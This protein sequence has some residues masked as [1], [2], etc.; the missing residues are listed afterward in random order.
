MHRRSPLPVILLLLVILSGVV[1]YGLQTMRTTNNEALKASGTIE[2]TVIR[3]SPEIAG[4]VKEIAVEEGQAVHQGDVLLRLDNALLNA[5]RNQA[6]AALETA[7]A[8]VR[9]AQANLEMAQA[10]YDAAL[11][12]A[13]LQQ[14]NQRLSDWAAR[15]PDVFAHPLWYFSHQEQ[16]D[17]AQAEVETARA[18]LEAAEQKVQALGADGNH[19]EFMAAEQRLNQARIAYQIAEQVYNRARTLGRSALSKNEELLNAANDELDKAE[20]ELKNAQETYDALLTTEQAQEVLKARAERSI[21]QE[22]YESALDRLQALRQGE[23]APQV[24]IAAAALEQAKTAL[25]Q[26]NAA[27]NQAQANLQTLDVQIQ[28][29]TLYAPRDGVILTRNAEIGEFFQP[30]ATVLTLA[31]L[32]TLTITVYIPEDRYGRLSLG[33]SAQVSVDSFPGETF[34]ASVIYI[35]SQA[36]FTPRNVQTVEGRSS[37][38]FA[39]K[40]RVEDPGHKLKP[41]MPADVIFE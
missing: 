7:Q 39:I 1:I 11:A 37:T 35:S 19:S 41:G 18:I 22:R 5:Q 28:R 27:V 29:L 17:A 16:L 32:D 30:G 33:Q 6:L 26:A 4:T 12:A 3:L 9:T 15:P 36:E 25:E 31:D 10:Q 38:V 14:S 20:Q 34:R 13:R 24:R 8:A 23:D 21:A 40:L 2:A